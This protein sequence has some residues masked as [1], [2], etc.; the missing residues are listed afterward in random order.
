MGAK[1]CSGCHKAEFAQWMKTVHYRI[2]ELLS[3]EAAVEY[4]LA[5]NLSKDNISK[6]SLCVTCY[7]TAQKKLSRRGARNF[8]GL[9]CVVS[10]A[11]GG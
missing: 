11:L 7:A 1:V 6:D 3:T 4:A 9:V 8:G 10:R 2:D 5:L